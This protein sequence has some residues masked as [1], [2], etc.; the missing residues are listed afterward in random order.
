MGQVPDYKGCSDRLPND[1]RPR[2]P[3]GTAARHQ[4]ALQR[5]LESRTDDPRVERVH[6]YVEVRECEAH[7]DAVGRV[8][9]EHVDSCERF[10]PG[11]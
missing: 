9:H 8:V 2:G 4:D 3:G 7:K 11:S 6:R 1:E 10:A 5:P